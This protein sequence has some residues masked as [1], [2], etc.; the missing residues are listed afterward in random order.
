[1]AGVEPASRKS[2]Q[3]FYNHS[4]LWYQKK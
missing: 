4:P 3:A 2:N 1:M